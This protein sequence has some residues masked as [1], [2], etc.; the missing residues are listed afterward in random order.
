M[1]AHSRAS[2]SRLLFE[3]EHSNGPNFGDTGDKRSFFFL[4]CQILVLAIRLVTPLS[5]LFLAWEFHFRFGTGRFITLWLRNNPQWPNPLPPSMECWVTDF[6]YAAVYHIF[7]LW[8]LVEAAFFPY[9]YYL[10]VRMGSSDTELEHFASDSESRMA[11]AK[12]CFEAMQIS[13]DTTVGADA[14][15][16]TSAG[17]LGPDSATANP[18]INLPESYMRKVSAQSPLR[19]YLTP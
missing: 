13:A 11:L 8:M 2:F 15:A 12:R 4:A 10:F 3:S 18:V 14:D 7:L 19:S 1:R 6:R 9:Y 5:Y 17:G 16:N